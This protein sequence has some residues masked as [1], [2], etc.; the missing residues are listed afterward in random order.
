MEYPQ[1]IQGGMGIG[2][3]NWNLAKHVSQLGQLG[4]VSGTSL[5]NVCARRLQMG[6]PEGHVRRAMEHFPFPEVAQRVLERYYIEGGKDE[7]K[8]FAPVPM[9]TVEP[10]APLVELTVVANFVEVF[11]AG[12]G[13]D[14]LVGINF[15]EKI[16]M[17]NVVSIFGA[18]LAGVDY[19][20]MEQWL[21]DNCLY[22]S[23]C[24]SVNAF[25]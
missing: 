6:D 20:I 7:D 1:I 14:G 5:D 23:I 9:Y 3:S 24:R 12:E 21:V 19:I 10:D 8:A 15:L 13:H 4:I 25:A 17:P 22:D 18:M 11:L 2:V 16:Q